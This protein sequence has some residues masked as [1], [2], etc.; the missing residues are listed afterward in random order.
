MRQDKYANFAELKRA[1]PVLAWRIRQHIR[2]KSPVLIIAPHAGRI[3]RG[4]SA[5]AALIAGSSYNLYL[6]EGRKP[7]GENQTLHITSHH[8]DEPQ[9]VALAARC[10]TVLGVHGCRGIWT[11]YVG[12]RDLAL[13]AKLAAALAETGIDVKANGPKFKAERPLNICNRGATG[14]GAQI[15][16]TLDLSMSPTWCR[17]ISKIIRAVIEDHLEMNAASA[18]RLRGN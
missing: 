12:G 18:G 6:F 13:R 8:F 16:L 5:L 4:T 7:R 3:E 15:E 10:T 2:R 17:R 14:R 9:A 1:E 11:I